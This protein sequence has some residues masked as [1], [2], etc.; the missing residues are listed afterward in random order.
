MENLNNPP[1]HSI[2]QPHSPSEASASSSPTQI[3]FLQSCF[4]WLQGCSTHR[5]PIHPIAKGPE[6]LCQPSSSTPSLSGFACHPSIPASDRY[7]FPLCS[8]APPDAGARAPH[9]RTRQTSSDGRTRGGGQRAGSGEDQI[10]FASPIKPGKDYGLFKPVSA[11]APAP[12][13]LTQ[14]CAVLEL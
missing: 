11:A 14:S 9:P 5:T 6:R 10:R 7:V 12:R 3:P 1:V 2:P 8:P 13:A 4:G